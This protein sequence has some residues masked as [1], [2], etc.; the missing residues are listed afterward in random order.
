M[1]HV[2]P[3]AAWAE[4]YKEAINRNQ[5]YRKAAHDWDQGAIALV[6]RPEPALGL[7][8]PQ[9]IVLDLEFGE[10]HG[11]TFATSSEALAQVPFII[12]A[13]YAT[14]KAVIQGK[15]DPIVAM[16]SSQLQLEKGPL[17]AL[18]KNVEGSHQLVASAAAIETQFS[19]DT[20]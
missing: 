9:A 4:A 20:P 5:H 12:E 11:V 1:G 14:W 7:E 13:D 19:D 3:S 6:C 15:L 16:L 8:S 17:P 18:L 2:F 10:C